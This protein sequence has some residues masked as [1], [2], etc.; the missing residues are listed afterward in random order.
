MLKF[1]NSLSAKQEEALN[2]I[3]FGSYLEIK[4]E[5]IPT[6]MAYWLVSNY[7]PRTNELNV[8]NHTIKITDQTVHDILGIPKGNISV[9]DQNKPRAD[10]SKTLKMWKSQFKSASRVK[11]SDILT[12]I[13]KSKKADFMFK[14]NWLVVH[15]TIMGWT[16]KCTTV[17]Q[18]FLKNIVKESDI[19]RMNW[20]EYLVSCLNETTSEWNGTEPFNGPLLFLAV[21]INNILIN[22][23]FI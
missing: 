20:C 16:S 1:I 4:I 18:R 7:D 3:G 15:N 21:R 23:F 22:Y 6:R 12:E 11:V 8:G 13:D 19:P 10:S 5:T 17:N 14:L 9:I 2:N